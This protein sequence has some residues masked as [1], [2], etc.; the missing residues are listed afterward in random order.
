MISQFS[1]PYDIEF[2]KIRR[3]KTKI[4]I[5]DRK[6]PEKQ[7]ESVKSVRWVEYMICGIGEF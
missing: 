1:L 2:G 6:T 5:N 7:S 3:N 4:K